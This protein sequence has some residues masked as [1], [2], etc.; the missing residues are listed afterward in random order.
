MKKKNRYNNNRPAR[1]KSSNL[2][3]ASFL[4]RDFYA[5]EERLMRTAAAIHGDCDA[6][7]AGVRR[8][9]DGV[10]RLIHDLITEAALDDTPTKA[11]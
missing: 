11:A 10:E 7:M 4:L 6:T 5:L 9:T 2:A 3:A 8:E 1:R